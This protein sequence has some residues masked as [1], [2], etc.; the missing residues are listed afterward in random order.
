[1]DNSSTY[2]TIL[3]IF[4]FYSPSI[5]VTDRIFSIET[6]LDAKISLYECK[7]VSYV[8]CS[9]SRRIVCALCVCVHAR[10]R[11]YVC[12]VY[13]CVYYVRIYYS[14]IVCMY[15]RMDDLYVMVGTDGGGWLHGEQVQAG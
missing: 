4:L 7:R 11:T 14:V 10:A 15:T 8:H 1:M 12:C 2:R 9:V 5:F 6:H 13:G 3:L